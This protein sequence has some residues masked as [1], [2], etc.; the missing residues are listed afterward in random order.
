MKCIH[1][2]YTILDAK[3]CNW[4]PANF[5]S[6]H[7]WIWNVCHRNECFLKVKQLVLK[8]SSELVCFTYSH[9]L[10]KEVSSQVNE[11]AKWV[12]KQQW[13]YV[14]M[15]PLVVVMSSHFVVTS[16]LILYVPTDTNS[17]SRT[18]HVHFLNCIPSHIY[19]VVSYIA[20]L[21]VKSITRQ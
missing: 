1:H 18:T 10:L 21:G 8:T 16:V 13:T 3:T 15:P 11:D 6:Q 17:P 5:C 12:S 9:A 14:V 20:W 19:C 2:N 7:Y 4:S